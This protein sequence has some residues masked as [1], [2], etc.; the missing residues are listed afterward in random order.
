ML[1]SEF[2]DQ[3]H[4]LYRKLGMPEYSEAVPAGN[5]KVCLTAQS[6]YTLFLSVD[7]RPYFAESSSASTHISADG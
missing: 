2:I 6:K 4:C 3:L 5:L 1:F 7:Q